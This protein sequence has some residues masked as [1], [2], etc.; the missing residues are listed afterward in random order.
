MAA[1][2]GTL[3]H[4]PRRIGNQSVFRELAF[5]GRFMGSDEALRIGLVSKIFEDQAQLQAGLL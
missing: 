1:D 3:Q 5:T 2:I 4:F